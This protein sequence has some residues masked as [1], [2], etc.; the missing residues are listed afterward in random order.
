MRFLPKDQSCL[1]LLFLYTECAKGRPIKMELQVDQHMPAKEVGGLSG[2]SV[3]HPK[4]SSATVLDS[5]GH[6]GNL[7]LNEMT[8][9]C[10]SEKDV[11]V[12]AVRPVSNYL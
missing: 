5:V 12:H 4:I 3:M 9:G 1:R 2:R 10:P 6:Y 7:G 11:P 8:K